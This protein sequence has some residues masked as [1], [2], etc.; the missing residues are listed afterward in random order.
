MSSTA[1]FPHLWQMDSLTTASRAVGI[2][3]ESHQLRKGS[4][5]FDAASE[6]VTSAVHPQM[7]P[8]DSVIS[9]G[10]WVSELISRLPILD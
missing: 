5:M 3:S 7:F 6:V 10:S 2:A 8:M 1:L 4:G 9:T